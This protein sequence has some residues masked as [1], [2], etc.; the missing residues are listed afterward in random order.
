MMPPLPRNKVVEDRDHI[1]WNG[2]TI[3]RIKINV[4]GFECGTE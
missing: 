1:T 4:S 2:R 3:G